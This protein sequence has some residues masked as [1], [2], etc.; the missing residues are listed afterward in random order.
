[1]KCDFSSTIIVIV[2]QSFF[3]QFHIYFYIFILQQPDLSKC[4]IDFN[5]FRYPKECTS[6]CVMVATFFYDK[7][8]NLY[9]KELWSTSSNKWVSLAQKPDNSNSDFMASIHLKSF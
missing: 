5:C 9:V 2:H 6:S 7:N 8:T 3:I 1:M 4:D